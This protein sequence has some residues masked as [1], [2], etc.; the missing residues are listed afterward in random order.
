VKAEVVIVNG[1]AKNV[2]EIDDKIDYKV[3]DLIFKPFT[4]HVTEIWGTDKVNGKRR[5]IERDPQYV[6][7]HILRKGFIGVIIEIDYK[8]SNLSE[9][10][11]CPQGD[12]I[13][14]YIP[15]KMYA[16]DRLQGIRYTTFRTLM[17]HESTVEFNTP[18]DTKP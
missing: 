13:R 16:K 8:K 10:E 14:V 9:G 12:P 11:V 18:K 4:K 5:A 3:E 17:T 2:Y 15:M 6:A 7:I 1:D